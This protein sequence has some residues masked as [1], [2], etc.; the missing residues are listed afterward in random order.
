MSECRVK[1]A[2]HTLHRTSSLMKNIH[3]K[4]EEKYSI[5]YIKKFQ[6]AMTSNKG[7]FLQLVSDRDHILE[8]V[9]LLYGASVKD[10]EEI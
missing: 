8:L 3:W 4:W 1:E 5:E 9:E 10:E 2:L 6:K 7:N